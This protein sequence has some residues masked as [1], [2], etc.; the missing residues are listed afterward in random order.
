MIAIHQEIDPLIE[1][2]KDAEDF[3]ANGFKSLAEYRD[4]TASN[5]G[6]INFYSV[7]NP[8]RAMASDLAKENEPI[9]ETMETIKKLQKETKEK[10]SEKE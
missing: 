10:E 3:L 4:P 8:N 2:K 1:Q 7:A 5:Y 6:Y 9:W